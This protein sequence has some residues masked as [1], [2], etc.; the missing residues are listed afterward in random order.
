MS[1]FDPDERYGTVDPNWSREELLRKEGIFKL[2][3]VCNLLSLNQPALRKLLNEELKEGKD[4]YRLYGL[5]REQ[6]SWIVRMKTF[7]RMLIKIEEAVGF[8]KKRIRTGRVPEGISYGD[9]F[10]LEGIFKLAD[11]ME[12]NFL[13]YSYEQITTLIKRGQDPEDDKS[14]TR[15]VCGC[16]LDPERSRFWLCNFQP[17]LA[18]ALSL[19]RG[20]SLEEAYKVIAKEN[21]ASS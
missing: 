17:F 16:W 13:P 2:T 14:F 6:G 7:A 20:V 15:E 4:T 3:H 1:L 12:P 18:F 21:A 9:F 8:R 5:R 11:V 10:K 19:W